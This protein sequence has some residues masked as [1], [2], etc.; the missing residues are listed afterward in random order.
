MDPMRLVDGLVS[1]LS[2]PSD[3]SLSDTQGGLADETEPRAHPRGASSASSLVSLDGTQGSG[4]TARALQMVVDDLSPLVSPI[5]PE[6]WT[7]VHEAGT[8]RPYFV[9]AELGLVSWEEPFYDVEE[10][11]W[12]A[13]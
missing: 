7:I 5:A 10:R 1:G 11:Q 9:N 8:G 2:S 13:P 4:L 6:G 3:S 12:Y